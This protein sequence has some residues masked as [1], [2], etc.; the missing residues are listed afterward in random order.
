MTDRPIPLWWFYFA[1][2][3]SAF[4]S[5]TVAAAS[6]ARACDLLEPIMQSMDPA[7]SV[8]MRQHPVHGY[9]WTGEEI[10]MTH[11]GQAMRGE[12]VVEVAD[13]K[14]GQRLEYLRMEKGAPLW[15]RAAGAL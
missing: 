12:G 7:Q 2:D 3:K 6:R 11:A 13:R 14:T 9:L 10:A 5:A 15:R 1:N 8:A 4:A